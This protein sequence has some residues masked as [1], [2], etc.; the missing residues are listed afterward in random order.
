MEII[1]NTFPRELSPEIQQYMPEDALFLDIET[2]GFQGAYQSCYLVG[3]L[4]RKKD[5]FTETQFFAETEAEEEA[6][7][8][9]FL[10]ELTA[11]K[12]I[13]TFNVDMFDLL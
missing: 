4:S 6:M 2:T 13:I 3:I 7:L 10:E 8:R 12:T 1:R 11:Y 5:S 9:A